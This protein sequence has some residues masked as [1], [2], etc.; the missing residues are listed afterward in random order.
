MTNLTD[1]QQIE[2]LFHAGDQA[3]MKTDVETL[4]QI[5]ADDYLQYD[6]AG[7]PQTRQRILEKLRSGQVRYLSIVSTGRSVRIFGKT[8][9]VHG[10]ERDEVEVNGTRFTVD[11]IY[12][13]VLLK[14]EGEWKL[15]SSLLAKIADK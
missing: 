1:E 9:I 11:Y 3:L 8:A 14:R 2:A 6:P 10:S 12:L 5:L 7:T 4:S 13:D 15:V